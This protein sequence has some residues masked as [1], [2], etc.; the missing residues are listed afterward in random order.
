MNAS[1]LQRVTERDDYHQAISTK[2]LKSMG[3]T[4]KTRQKASTMYAKNSDVFS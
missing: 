3:I 2:Y 1:T 4:K